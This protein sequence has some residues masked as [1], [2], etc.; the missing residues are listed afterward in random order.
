MGSTH[1]PGQAT[2]VSHSTVPPPV[3]T[4]PGSKPMTSTPSRI[5]APAPRARSA[6]WRTVC[7]ASAQ[8]PR[9]SWSTASTGASQ[10]GQLHV[11]YSRQ[12]S[13]PV[14]SSDS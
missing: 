2:T 7:M 9:R 10:S 1:G 5:S 6:R 13:A 14:T 12:A 8:P 3:M 4:E 11:R